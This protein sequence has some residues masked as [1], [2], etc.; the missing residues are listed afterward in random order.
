M[1]VWCVYGGGG[2]VTHVSPPRPMEVKKL[3]AKR[4]FFGLSRGRRP[5]NA[6]LKI[7]HTH[8]HTHTHIHTHTHTHTQTHT[9]IHVYVHAH[10]YNG[11]TDL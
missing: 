11:L 4:V 8:T 5:S 7:L 2:G 6:S 1:C 3:M 9:H 10:Y